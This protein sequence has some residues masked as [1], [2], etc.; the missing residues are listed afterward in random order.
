MCSPIETTIFVGRRACFTCGQSLVLRESFTIT[1]T[2]FGNCTYIICCCRQSGFTK[3][4]IVYDPLCVQIFIQIIFTLF[5]TPKI[6]SLINRTTGTHG[7]QKWRHLQMKRTVFKKAIVRI[8]YVNILL[9]CTFAKMIVIIGLSPSR[10]KRSAYTRDIRTISSRQSLKT[11]ACIF[12]V[13]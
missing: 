9:G 10:A 6:C 3:S 5:F 1:G 2:E 4:E 8:I 13:L 7:C 11:V 12:N